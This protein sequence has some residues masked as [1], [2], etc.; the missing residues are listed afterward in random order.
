V[1]K[2]GRRETVSYGGDVEKKDE[3]LNAMGRILRRGDFNVVG[4]GKRA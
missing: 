3:M 2:R 4:D 1:W